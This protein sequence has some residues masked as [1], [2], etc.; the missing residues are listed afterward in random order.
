MGCGASKQQVQQPAKV[1][2]KGV[3]ECRQR[4][5]VVCVDVSPE[6][7]QLL[8]ACPPLCVQAS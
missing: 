6:Q 4:D 8:C 7:G 2:L 3:S 1:H 5:S